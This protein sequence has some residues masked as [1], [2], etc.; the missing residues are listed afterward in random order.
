MKNRDTIIVTICIAT[1]LV[2]VA[3]TFWGNYKNN[4]VLSPD[5]FY[6]V[7]ATFIGICAT[8]IVG[9]QIVSFVKIH[10]VER[11]MKEVQN[12]RD[13]MEDEK[14]ELQYKIDF[15]ENELSNAFTILAKISE[16]KDFRILARL[17]SIACS[18][19]IRDTEGVLSRYRALWKELKDASPSEIPVTIDLAYKIKNL[20]IP[21]GIEHYA[22]IMELHIKTI[23]KLE[24]ASSE[25]STKSV[26]G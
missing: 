11:Q 6:G 22:E 4:G 24:K 12:E 1:A 17:L 5:A 19:F 9:F 7:I 21:S 16:N 2:C 14:G 26:N 20:S 18:N 15:V 13:R 3:L 8:F 10:E 25:K 23:R